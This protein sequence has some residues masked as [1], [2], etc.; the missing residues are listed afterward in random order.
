MN[1]KK[2]MIKFI[3][4]KHDDVG[5]KYGNKPYSYHPIS[6]SLLVEK[7]LP[8]YPRK[9]LLILS[10]LGHDLYEDTDT[11][12]EEL[13]KI[14]SNDVI[15]NIKRVTDEKGKNRLERHLNTYYKIREKE[16]AV[17][18]KLFDRIGNILESRNFK[19]KFD[20]YKKE[21]LSFKFA[22]YNPKHLYAKKLWTVY[23][24]LFSGNS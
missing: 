2:E 3:K 14:V 23:D 5:Q 8:D 1:D 13:S 18:V 15:D 10:I 4:K 21:N 19:K 16:E 24:S 6:V 11:T 17:L 22:L 9:E 12:D 7:Y 20:M